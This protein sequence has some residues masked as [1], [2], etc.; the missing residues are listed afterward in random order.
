MLFTCG[1]VAQGLVDV[2]GTAGEFPD[3]SESYAL[4]RRIVYT[5][6]S[7]FGLKMAAV[8]MFVTSMIGL[9]TGVLSRWVT[10]LG[11]AVGLVFLLSVTT[12]A[13]VAVVFPCWVMLVSTWI[14]LADL[15]SMKRAPR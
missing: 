15:R 9:R 6:F 5:W 2:F 10:I 4:G 13:W 8:F 1:A 14:L 7:T 11:F 3:K 12:Y